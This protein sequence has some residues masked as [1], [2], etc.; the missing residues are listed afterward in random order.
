MKIRYDIYATFENG[1]SVK[2]ECH[3]KLANAQSAV[4]AM[5]IH[6]KHDIEQGAGF[7]YGVPTYSI[8]KVVI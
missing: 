8:L 1:A 5:N 6:N 3:T 7:P 2:V 4:D